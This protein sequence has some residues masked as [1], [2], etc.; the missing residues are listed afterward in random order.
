MFEVERIQ[1][2]KRPFRRRGRRYCLSSIMNGPYYVKIKVQ[3]LYFTVRPVE[4]IPRQS[5]ILDSRM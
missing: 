2:F 5:W 4:G 3:R 1:L